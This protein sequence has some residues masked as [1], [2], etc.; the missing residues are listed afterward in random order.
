MMTALVPYLV[1]SKTQSPDGT[2]LL[3][4]EFLGTVVLVAVIATV[5]GG[6]AA[7][8][9]LFGGRSGLTGESAF[10]AREILLPMAAI[11]PFG[12]LGGY[13]AANVMADHRQAN[14]LL[15]GVPAFC[16]VVLLLI[17]P[18]RSPELLAWATLVGVL[19]HQLL[20]LCVQP[21]GERMPRP[22]FSWRSPAWRGIIQGFGWVILGNAFC[23]A[24]SVADQIMVAPLGS[25]ANA[26]LGYANR[27]VALFSGLGAT[28][29]SRAILP[30]L[31][32]LVGSDR[33]QARRVALRWTPILFVAGAVLTVSAWIAAPWGV[34]L[35]YQRGAFTAED[36]ANVVEAFRLGTLR[37]PLYFSAIVLVQLVAGGR[38]YRKFLYMGIIDFAT[39][40]TGNYF[41]VPLFGIGGVQLSECAM[42]A[43]SLLTLWVF[44]RRSSS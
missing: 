4:R 15:E 6:F 26:T 10:F 29:I 42:Y 44:S 36:T 9:G 25:G 2:G 30:V 35:L 20:L 43:A 24:T 23:S 32:E 21:K 18:T 13:F 16:I 19:I 38:D 41:L 31:S 28:A 5:V 17:I 3:K 33:A 27:L 40:V 34:A 37:F 12:I 14:T 1:H 22:S 39:K 11:M 7:H 8:F